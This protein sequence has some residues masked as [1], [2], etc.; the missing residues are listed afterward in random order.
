MM[1]SAAK[2]F[3]A[4]VMGIILTGMGNDGKAGMR[5]IKAGG[6]VTIAESEESSVIYGMPREVILAGDADKILSLE[7]I[8]AEII[9]CL[10]GD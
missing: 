6:G 9:S 4:K 1:K 8:P 2:H 3:G 10:D 7:D 5:E